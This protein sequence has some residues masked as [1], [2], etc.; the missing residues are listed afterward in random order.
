M[1]LLYRTVVI[2][3]A[4]PFSFVYRNFL[5]RKLSHE[6]VWTSLLISPIQNHFP[7]SSRITDLAL[8]SVPIRNQFWKNESFSHLAGLLG[9]AIGHTQDTRHKYADIHPCLTF[10]IVYLVA[11]SLPAV[12]V[13]FLAKVKVKLSLCF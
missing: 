13:H 7:S 1:L 8:W 4:F 3:M 12:A 9:R 6:S 10:I 11:I 2:L 5:L